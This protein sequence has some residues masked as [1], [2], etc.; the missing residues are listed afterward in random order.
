MEPRT[1]TVVNTNTQSKMAFTSE[2]E[3]LAELK[4]DLQRNNIDFTDMAFFEGLTK[5]ELVSDKTLLPR[6]IL[7]KGTTTNQLVIMLTTQQKKIKSGMYNRQECY[8]IVKEKDLQQN[9]IANYNRNYTQVSTENLNKII[10]KE[11]AVEVAETCNQQEKPMCTENE[12]YSLAM[13]ITK[14]INLRERVEDLEKTLKE[15]L[16]K[17]ESQVSCQM[18]YDEKELEEIMN[19]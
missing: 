14:V 3:T 9:V 2:A 15:A 1:I 4:T 5:V 10:E 18:P 12:E 6:D 7:Y 17:K 13:L 16:D 19:F 8:K 11:E